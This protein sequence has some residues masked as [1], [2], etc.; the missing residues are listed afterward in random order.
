MAY[1]DQIFSFFNNNLMLIILGVGGLAL[2]MYLYKHFLEN[3][4]FGGED[5]EDRI[6]KPF[7]NILTTLGKSLNTEIRYRLK[8]LGVIDQDY[9]FSIVKR[10]S[11]DKKGEDLNN[12]NKIK[13]DAFNVRPKADSPAGIINYMLWLIFDKL[14]GLGWF[15]NIFLVPTDNLSR[16][17]QIIIDKDIDF[18]VMAGIFVPK[19]KRGKELI[20]SQA[21]LTHYKDTLERFSNL[22]QFMNFLDTQF[23]KNIQSMEKSYQ[24]EKEKWLGREDNVVESG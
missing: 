23:S 15:E 6:K 18:T 2:G 19:D 1:V 16:K 20:E 21:F 3:E 14:A 8:S 7:Y 12:K 9:Y 13:W 11:R 22:I 4:K 24:L 10:D 17:D 5:L